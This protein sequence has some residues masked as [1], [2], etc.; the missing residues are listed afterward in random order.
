[1]LNIV[2]NKKKIHFFLNEYAI[3]FH[4]VKRENEYFNRGFATHEICIF[5]FTL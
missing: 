1:M 5:G 2:N 3:L 4:L